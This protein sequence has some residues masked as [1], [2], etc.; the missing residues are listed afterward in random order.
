MIIALTIT[1]VVAMMAGALVHLSLTDLNNTAH[2][3]D[4]MRAHEM[5]QSGLNHAIHELTYNPAFQGKLSRTVDDLSYEVSFDPATAAG[6]RSTN[7]LMNDGPCNTLGASGKTIYGKQVELISV[8]SAG[9]VKVKLRALAVRGF[10]FN[11]ALGLQGTLTANVRGAVTLD[12]IQDLATSRPADGGV[13]AGMDSGGPTVTIAGTVTMLNQARIETARGLV[14]VNAPSVSPGKISAL[15]GNSAKIPEFDVARV[16]SEKLTT[17]TRTPRELSPIAGGFALPSCSISQE[18]IVNGD[19]TVN[20]DLNITDGTLFVKGNLTVNGGVIGVGSVFVDG[21]VNIQGGTSILQTNQSTGAAIFASQDVNL[22]GLNTALYLQS[23]ATSHPASQLAAKI[24][25][26]QTAWT[27]FESAAAAASPGATSAACDALVALGDG[28]IYGAPPWINPLPGASGLRALQSQNAPLPALLTELRTA[29]GPSFNTDL[30]AQKIA[31][32]LEFEA[33]AARG[34]FRFTDLNPSQ[35]DLLSGYSS[36]QIVVPINPASDSPHV[37]G[38]DSGRTFTTQ[39]GPGSPFSPATFASGH[40]ISLHDGSARL[41]LAFSSNFH[42][43]ANPAGFLKD[44]RQGWN[45]PWS[46]A[47]P[48]IAQLFPYFRDMTLDHQRAILNYG[49]GAPYQNLAA[50]QLCDA[51]KAFAINHPSDLSWLSRSA[52]QGLV[53]AGGNINLTDSFEV[54][55]ALL[56]QGN[57]VLN[58]TDFKFVYNQEYFRHRGTIGPL[59]LSNIEQL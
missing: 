24:T 27:S 35:M 8:A 15:S 54:Y 51:L 5:A 20:G 56:S 31:R 29:L 58:G 46:A 17:V 25:A 52:F 3:R 4:R 11:R 19:L 9:R 37:V 23:L 44:D 38:L 12:G 57:V 22:A 2:T 50:R 10:S 30:K 36:T 33:F 43:P 21:D 59:S 40:S 18:C 13:Y 1:I 32:A 39:Y 45:Q 47:N 6:S 28:I 26:Y 41:P 16:V 55:G 48:D 53:Y 7:N 42:D 34:E 49:L 14:N